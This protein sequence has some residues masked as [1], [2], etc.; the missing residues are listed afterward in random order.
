[1]QGGS[2]GGTRR[3]AGAGPSG[4][5]AGRRV[6]AAWGKAPSGDCWLEWGG[7]RVVASEGWP[8]HDSD[9]QTAHSPGRAARGVTLSGGRRR[10]WRHGQPR[11]LREDTRHGPAVSARSRVSACIARRHT[12]LSQPHV[13]RRN[14]VPQGGTH[15]GSM[16]RIPQGAARERE[17]RI[18]SCSA[19]CRARHVS[20]RR[21][22]PRRA[23]V[24]GIGPGPPP[25]IQPCAVCRITAALVRTCSNSPRAPVT[26]SDGLPVRNDTQ[27]QMLV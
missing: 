24:Q 26:S 10:A 7:P 20:R 14:R 12:P 23:L 15:G 13:R 8:G 19:G 5:R 18:L 9:A 16:N 6:W 25:V 21:V 1:V 22:S 17:D 27:E 2:G 4:G 11:V 3:A